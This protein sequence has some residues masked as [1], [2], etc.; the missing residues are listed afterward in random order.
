MTHRNRFARNAP[1]ATSGSTVVGPL[2]LV[3]PSA[4]DASTGPATEG[5]GGP[6]D[7]YE[8]DDDIIARHTADNSLPDPPDDDDDI[9]AA[10]YDH[11]EDE[12]TGG[13][14]MPQTAPP[15][16]PKNDRPESWS[17]R[18]KPKPRIPAHMYTAP[19]FRPGGEEGDDSMDAADYVSAL[20]GY[21][22]PGMGGFSDFL[23]TVGKDVGVEVLN[24]AS[25]AIGGSGAL[26]KK[27]IVPPPPPM[28]M[29]AKI[30]IGIAIALPV[31]YFL[32]RSHGG[33]SAPLV[34]HNP[35]R[36]RRSRRRR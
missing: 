17:Y 21:D 33:S 20:N 15:A 27:I 4:E 29:A 25:K 14:D 26:P 22:A 19:R 10:G 3:R 24:D 8:S 32:T 16:A 23:K 13:Q 7:S 5:D 2:R 28:S 1:A 35:F 36:R 9:D 12:D 30:G 11:D 34:A 6:S 18:N 31:L